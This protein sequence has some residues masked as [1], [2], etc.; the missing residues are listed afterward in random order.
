MLDINIDQINFITDDKCSKIMYTPF[1]IS[2]S[3]NDNA[4]GLIASV[5]FSQH[6]SLWPSLS[7]LSSSSP[8]VSSHKLRKL[9]RSKLPS[10]RYTTILFLPANRRP[11]YILHKPERYHL[12]EV[13]PTVMSLSW[14]PSQ[15]LRT[16]SL[17]R[18]NCRI[19]IQ[20][21][22]QHS[23]GFLWAYRRK[24]Q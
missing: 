22:N 19:F 21:S 7:S 8:R 15:V 17:P 20:S 23:C 4:N 1:E 3:K 5:P 11:L 24:D 12:R 14:K 9:L 18:S 2:P 16:A 10:R 6:Y 13:L